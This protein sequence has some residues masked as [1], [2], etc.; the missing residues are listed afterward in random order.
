MG[1]AW[2]GTDVALT[3]TEF[4]VLEILVRRAGQVISKDEMTEQALNRK[5]TPYDRSIDVHVSNI[6]KKI[7]AAGSTKDLIINVRSAGYML[8]MNSDEST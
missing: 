3:G 1:S 7:T 5:L 8:T 4:S 2:A 6:R